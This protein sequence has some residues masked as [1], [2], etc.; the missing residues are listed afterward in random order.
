MSDEKDRLG[1]KLHQAEMAR[2]NQWA[3]QN[4]AELIERLRR[5]YVKAVDCPHCGARLDARVAIGV[6]GMACS[7]HHGA[8]VDGEALEQLSARLEKVAAIHHESLGER[9]SVGLAEIVERLRHR[10]PKEID[11]PDCGAK[12]DARV[13]MTPGVGGLALA[14]IAC[15]NGHGAWIDQE[16]LREIRTRLDTAAGTHIVGSSNR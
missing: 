3:R 9:V 12:L 5:K 15:P 7:S 13:A 10:H 11:C 6:G 14:G 4:D 8:W 16:M 2:E 1:D